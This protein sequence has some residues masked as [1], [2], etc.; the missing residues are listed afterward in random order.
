MVTP[1]QPPDWLDEW[2]AD[3]LSGKEPTKPLL[4]SYSPIYDCRWCRHPQHGLK[5]TTCPCESSWTCRDD[6]WRPP[7]H[8]LIDKQ[9]RELCDQTGVDGWVAKFA[10]TG[11]ATTPTAVGATL[12]W[13]IK[14]NLTNPDYVNPDSVKDPA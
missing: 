13:R 11:I 6:S 12:A 14:A 1:Q 5:C 2:L 8:S 10:V 7:V 4:G 9:K 3:T